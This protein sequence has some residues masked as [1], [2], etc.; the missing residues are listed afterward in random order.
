[1]GFMLAELIV[2][3]RANGFAPVM[4]QVDALTAGMNRTKGRADAL[5]ES[6]QRNTLAPTNAPLGFDLTTPGAED[7]GTE[8]PDT[9]V[10]VDDSSRKAADGLTV[11]QQ[12]LDAL[13]AAVGGAG[14]AGTYGLAPEE[15][16]FYG[17][18]PEEAPPS[19]LPAGRGAKLP[20]GAALPAERGTGDK[21]AKADRNAGDVLKGLNRER[22]ETLR[23]QRLGRALGDGEAATAG[24]L[25]QAWLRLRGRSQEVRNAFE[26]KNRTMTDA[27]IKERGYTGVQA[28]L[29]KGLVQT[30]L[31]LGKFGGQLQRVQEAFAPLSSAAGTAF[32]MLA[33]GVMGFVVAGLRGTQEGNALTQRFTML[34]REIAGIFL[35]VIRGAI[36]AVEKVFTWLHKLSGAQQHNIMNFV[37]ATTSGLGLAK[38][39][40]GPL[41]GGLQ[42]ALRGI[43]ALITGAITLD[44]VTGFILPAIGAVVV[45]IGALAVGTDAGRE[46][47][48]DLY[49]IFA[50]Y[51]SAVQPII[52]VFSDFIG[53]LGLSKTAILA[54]IPAIGPVLAVLDA[55]K[56][57]LLG[58]FSRLH[59][60]IRLLAAAWE[61]FFE[62]IRGAVSEL[63]PALA[64]LFSRDAFQGFADAL[65]AAIDILI[66]MMDR[67]TAGIK[68][69]RIAI[70][71]ARTGSLEQARADVEAEDK[72][73]ADMA[74][75][76]AEDRKKGEGHQLPAQA[77]KGFEG[78]QDIYKRLNQAAVSKNY[79]KTTAD[80][81]SKSAKWLEDIKNAVVKGQPVPPVVVR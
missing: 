32:K 47:L 45:A 43:Q 49:D 23:L 7:L 24:M 34:S 15:A 65:S 35:P 29:F 57:P 48:K 56:E 76:R 28:T 64:D 68:M 55:F 9:L 46:G 30:H 19:V 41:L 38:V 27:I 4:R 36:S 26:Q 73:Q 3:L 20:T 54:L 66:G 69:A 72:R 70:Q 31:A 80:A 77:G 42:A 18:A 44:T 5:S 60:T 12:Q 62:G 8:L 21:E 63:A 51:V 78:V 2:D 59:P 71:F 81:T 16:P 50:G 33:G 67:L 74:K 13:N 40:S 79:D 14:T 75:Q 1:M 37:L 6:L 39:L 58:F 17:L 10:G 53:Q 52:D 11:L 22:R 61:R 25:G